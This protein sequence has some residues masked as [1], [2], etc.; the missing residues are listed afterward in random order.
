MLCC[1]NL[2]HWLWNVWRKRT[3]KLTSKNFQFA[4]NN[5]YGFFFLYT[6][7]F[8]STIHVAFKL[9][10][11]PFYEFYAKIT[12][13]CIKKCLVRLLSK[14]LTSKLVAENYVKKLMLWCHKD[15][16]TACMRVR[17]LSLIYMSLAR[18]LNWSFICLGTYFN[19]FYRSWQTS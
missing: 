3:H 8:P 19:R 13:F 15:Y 18:S 9:Q 6:S 2:R 14:T 16:L 11:A 4:P 1:D 5:H 12:V 10:Y 7:T 17:G